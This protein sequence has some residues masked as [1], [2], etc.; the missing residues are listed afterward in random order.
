[1]NRSSGIFVWP[2]LKEVASDVKS[3]RRWLN[4]EYP[5][6]IDWITEVADVPGLVQWVGPR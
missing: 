3:N 4:V 2:F 5:L 1:M 6:E